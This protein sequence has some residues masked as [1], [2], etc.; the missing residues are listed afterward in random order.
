MYRVK[1]QTG[2][3]TFDDS[4]DSDLPRDLHFKLGYSLAL[5][6]QH[7]VMLRICAIVIDRCHVAIVSCF[8]VV[9]VDMFVLL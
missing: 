8:I 5:W 1:V 6:F 4:N 2:W 7:V 9:D 3:L